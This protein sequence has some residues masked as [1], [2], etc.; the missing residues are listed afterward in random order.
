LNRKACPR[1]RTGGRKDAT[2]GG[3]MG[4]KDWMKKRKLKKLAGVAALDHGIVKGEGVPHLQRWEQKNEV[5]YWDPMSEKKAYAFYQSL[6]AVM[7]NPRLK[8]IEAF[9][10]WNAAREQILK[11]AEAEF[12]RKEGIAADAELSQ[13]QRNRLDEFTRQRINHL[14]DRLSSRI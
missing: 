3:I 1:L 7:D 5:K 9:G 13:A 2:M 4:I 8:S 14:N 11:T 12:R 6:A 10:K